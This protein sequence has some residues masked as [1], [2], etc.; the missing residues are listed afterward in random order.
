MDRLWMRQVWIGCYVLLVWLLVHD[1]T[2]FSFGWLYGMVWFGTRSWSYCCF[3][4]REK[5]CIMADKFKRI[6]TLVGCM[7]PSKNF[8]CVI[9]TYTNLLL[10]PSARSSSLCGRRHAS[11]RVA[12]DTERVGG[13]MWVRECEMLVLNRIIPFFSAHMIIE[14]LEGI[15]EAFGCFDLG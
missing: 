14:N 10:G 5:H 8:I 3:I 1:D 4:V 9:H 2:W 15:F 12:E 13:E 7:G 11:P 6:R